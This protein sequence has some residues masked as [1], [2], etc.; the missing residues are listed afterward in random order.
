MRE[1][2]QVFKILSSSLSQTI[3]IL[4]FILNNNKRM[5]QKGKLEYRIVVENAYFD[6]HR[7]S[8]SFKW[9]VVHDLSIVAKSLGFQGKFEASVFESCEMREKYYFRDTLSGDVIFEFKFFQNKNAHIKMSQAFLMSLNVE[10][11]KLKGWINNYKDVEA[12]FDL[13][14]EEAKQYFKNGLELI[15]MKSSLPLLGM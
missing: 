6:N 11:G 15:G 9:S 2:Y 5:P 14:E 10:I 12:E 1:V 13:R 3:M 4:D 7:W 8:N